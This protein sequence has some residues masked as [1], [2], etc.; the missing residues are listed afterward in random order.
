[1]PPTRSRPAPQKASKKPKDDDHKKRDY[2]G[3]CEGCGFRQMRRHYHGLSKGSPLVECK[4]CGAWV[5]VV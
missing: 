4:R 2:Q 1:M 3:E 5:Y